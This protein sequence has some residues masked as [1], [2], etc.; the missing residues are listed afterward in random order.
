MSRSV[1]VPLGPRWDTIH[2]CMHVVVVVALHSWN[3]WR[4]IH[5]YSEAQEV[6]SNVALNPRRE[7]PRRFISLELA[8]DGN[9]GFTLRRNIHNDKKKYRQRQVENDKRQIEND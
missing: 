4:I 6:W 5:D 7:S 9:L 1:V 3:S 8:L 2:V